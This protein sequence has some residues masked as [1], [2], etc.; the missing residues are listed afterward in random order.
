MRDQLCVTLE[1]VENEETP[2]PRDPRQLDR[3]QRFIPTDRM[4]C[5]QDDNVDDVKG[6]PL[7]KRLKSAG[8]HAFI[9]ANGSIEVRSKKGFDR[10]KARVPQ[11]G[12]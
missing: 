12:S 9:G 4:Y 1:E 10:T 5:V 3:T 11:E 7:V 6:H 8:E 2:F